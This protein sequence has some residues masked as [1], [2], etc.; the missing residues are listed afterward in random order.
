MVCV[1]LS[2]VRRSTVTVKVA[3]VMEKNNKNRKVDSKLLAFIFFLI[4]V[5]DKMPHCNLTVLPMRGSTVIFL[6]KAVGRYTYTF[7]Q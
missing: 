7:A 1:L 6:G 3:H 2:S 5:P 4:S